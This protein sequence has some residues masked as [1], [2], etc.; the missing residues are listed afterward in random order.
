MVIC[1]A[2]S[3][4]ANS[5]QP[6][7]TRDTST[8]ATG[9]WWRPAP[10]DATE[11]DWQITEPYRL[12]AVRPMYDLDLFDLAT[13]GSRLRYPNGE[14]IEVLAGPNAGLVERLHRRQPRTVVICYVDTGAYE[15]YRPDAHRFPG[16]RPELA[17]MPNRPLPPEPG[18]VVGRDTGW[19]GERWLDI[20]PA[21]RSRFASTIWARLDLAKRLGCDGVEPDQNNP[22][23]NDSGFPVT[24][25][26]QLSWYRE[27]AKQAHARGLSVGLKN[28]HDQPG[29]AAKLVDD[30][31]WALP[32]ECVEFSECDELLPFVRA[33]KA[34]FAVDYAAAGDAATVCAE[35]RRRGFDGLVKDEPPSGAQR[36][37]C[38]G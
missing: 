15:H 20:R 10:G 36:T 38:R 14:S 34:V 23:D 30:F 37:Q 12:A 8:S 19:D 6:S 2:V 11:W 27:V 1:L 18:S 26:D 22:M 33:G 4:C 7:V 17:S 13:D 32:E 31:D 35:H 28:G 21:A 3:G 24:L 29:A 16:H 5:P 25:A 9:R